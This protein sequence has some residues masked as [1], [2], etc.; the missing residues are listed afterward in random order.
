MS[1]IQST[2]KTSKKRVKRSEIVAQKLMDAIVSGQFETGSRLPSESVMAKEFDVSRAT[3]REAFKKLEQMGAIQ[4]KQGS[5]TYVLYQHKPEGERPAAGTG[6]EVAN[7]EEWVGSI[8]NSLFTFSTTGFQVTQYVD[9][10][11]AVELAAA[12]L[13]VVC[14]DNENYMNLSAIMQKADEPDNTLE[15]CINCDCMFH[16]ELVRASKNDFLLQFWAILEPCLREQLS[17]IMDKKSFVR[18]RQLHH[19]IFEALLRRDKK[20]MIARME[21]HFSTILGRFFLKATQYSKDSQE[22]FGKESL[23]PEK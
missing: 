7:T 2:Q 18:S 4:A 20:E 21:E 11:R 14:A 1:E 8:V 3:L 5:G 6:A 19:S 17:R 16:R 23:A 10:R 12:E 15:D 9:A 13:A 22:N